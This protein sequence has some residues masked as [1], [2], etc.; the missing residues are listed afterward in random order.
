MNT[1]ANSSAIEGAGTRT[2]DET[3]LGPKPY[4][5][6]YAAGFGLGLVLLAAFVIMGRGLGHRA[7]SVHWSPRLHT[8]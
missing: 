6:P 4:S 5:N 8:R 7:L 2:R 3:A 1:E